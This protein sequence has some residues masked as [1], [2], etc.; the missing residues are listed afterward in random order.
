MPDEA[1]I[2]L[3]VPAATKAAWVRESRAAGMRLTDWII[4]RVEAQ[5]M[6]QITPIS[7]PADLT[8]ADLK[9][10]RDSDGMVSFDTSVISR[11]EA[12][13]GLPDGFFMGQHEGAVAELLTHWYR[14]HID[15]GG[16][17]D[18]VQEDLIAETRA[19]DVRGGGFS[20]QPGRA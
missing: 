14:L 16:A 12:A 5:Q 19:E 2:H 17:P 6:Q 20:H 18:A 4:E 13:S 10:A 9:L 8:F 7:I 15:G 3:R 1:L 11:I